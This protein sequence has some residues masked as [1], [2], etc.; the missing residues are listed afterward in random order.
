MQTRLRATPT[1][2]AD[3]KTIGDQAK[4]FRL[5]RGWSTKQ[6]A[7][8]CKTSR[9][10]IETL[11]SKGDRVPRYIKELAHVM[12]TTVDVLME[13]RYRASSAAVEATPTLSPAMVER[14]SHEP[15]E[16][17]R[18]LRV[19]A[20]AVAGVDK[21]TQVALERL[22]AMLL[23]EPDQHV[24][25]AHAVCKLMPTTPLARRLHDDEGEGGLI[26]D[27]PGGGMIKSERVSDKKRETGGR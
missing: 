24:N 18:A 16:I 23:A 11:E 5:A 3:M 20:K 27:L 21:P 15:D 19:L 12:G 17:A 9:Q 8:A 7:A 4:A 13:G 14:A 22:F 1:K 2:S 26:V 6:M 25:I 10:N